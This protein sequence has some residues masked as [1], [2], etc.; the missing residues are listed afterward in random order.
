MA[1]GCCYSSCFI[2]IHPKD[3]YSGL[4]PRSVRNYLSA[5]KA[6]M[7]RF[8]M[9]ISSFDNVIEVKFLKALPKI[10]RVNFKSTF[11]IDQLKMLFQINQAMGTHI[12][13]ATAF[14]LFAFLCT[15]NLVPS[16]MQSFQGTKQLTRGD[17]KFTEHGAV[18]II[19]WAMNFG[20][21]GPIP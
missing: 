9:D 20:R 7:T 14:A 21:I 2:S 15:S 11:T 4:A 6:V 12:A 19:K 3:V 8:G 16:S 10:P 5:L 1:L 13:C 18:I 17:V